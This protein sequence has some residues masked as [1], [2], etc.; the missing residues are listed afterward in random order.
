MRF[1]CREDLR[2]DIVLV[3]NMKIFVICY[4]IRIYNNNIIKIN[5][6]LFINLK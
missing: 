6:L 1:A 4:K 3:G 5:C 2:V